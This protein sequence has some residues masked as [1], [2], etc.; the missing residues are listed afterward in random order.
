MREAVVR[1]VIVGVSF[2]LLASSGAQGF[3]T[4]TTRATLRGLEGVHVVVEA[5]KAEAERDGLTRT[6]IQTDV[7]LRLRKAGIRVFTQQ[8]VVHI[9]GQPWLYVRVGTLK[10]PGLELYVDSIDVELRQWVY[11]ARH[12]NLSR[13]PEAPRTPR[14]CDGP[15]G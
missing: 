15:R 9:P 7:E 6:Q 11:L 8:E 3:D 5:L 1:C 13:F 4:E 10:H 14:T 2:L 12:P